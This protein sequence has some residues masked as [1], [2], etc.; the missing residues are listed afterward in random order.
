MKPEWREFLLNRGAE[1]ADG[2]VQTFGNPERELRV[3]TVG[4]VLADLSHTGLIAAYGEDTVGFLQGQVTSDVRRV[5]PRASQLSAY[6]SPKGRMLATFRIFQR[7]ETLYLSMPRAAVEPTLKRL[8]MFVLRAKVTLEDASDSLVRIGFSGPDAD[9]QL[10]EQLGAAPGAP[11]QALQSGDYTTIRIPAHHPRFE[12]YGE[13]E[14]MKKL[15]TSLDVHAAPVGR[16]HWHLLDVRAA[17]PVVYPETVDAFVPQMTNLQILDG[18]SFK[19]GC[20]TGQEVVARMQYLGKLKRRMFRAH[21]DAADAPPPGTA[22]FAPGSSSG[23]G[24][25]KVVTAAPAPDGGWELLAVV[26]IASQAAGDVRLGDAD[27][28]RLTFLDLPYA[29]PD[30]ST[31]PPA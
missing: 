21:T 17:V 27:G 12:I 15:W 6:C 24:V 19:K 4:N 23:Q 26:E 11:H 14:P 25:G 30:E 5:S 16:D 13:L 22:L 10:R 2:S 20:Y 7:G 28:P 31:E 18:I 3:V 9:A 8:R 1:F 29:V